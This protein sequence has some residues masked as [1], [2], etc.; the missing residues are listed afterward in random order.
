MIALKVTISPKTQVA[1]MTVESTGNSYKMIFPI[2]IV[3][4]DHFG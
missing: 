1:H 4:I 3:M 2:I